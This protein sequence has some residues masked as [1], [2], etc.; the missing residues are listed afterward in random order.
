[1][2]TPYPC[3]CVVPADFTVKSVGSS[4][5]SNETSVNFASIMYDQG[6]SMLG[7]RNMMFD[8]NLFSEK[9]AQQQTNARI[10]EAVREVKTEPTVF[11]FS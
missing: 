8:V 3:R 2:S 4:S 6:E 10:R 1:M 11:Y 9:Y 7:C 5:E